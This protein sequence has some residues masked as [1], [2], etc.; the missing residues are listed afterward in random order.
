M[1]S[2]ARRSLRTTA[3]AAGIAALSVGIA[4]H[5]FAAP[6]APALPGADGLGAAPAPAVPNAD[7]SALEAMLGTAQSGNVSELPQ[8]FTFEGPTVNTAGPMPEFAELGLPFAP[9]APEADLLQAP[10][11]PAAGPEAPELAAPE[12][13]AAPAAPAAP[14][15]D[16][17]GGM[18][19]EDNQVTGPNMD[20]T[21]ADKTNNVGALS[22]MDTAKMMA[23]MAQKAMSG[24]SASKGN[25]I[26]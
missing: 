3:A 4:G 17:L 21:S 19:G 5:A 7:A 14:N 6:E 12:L 23:G 26:G 16:A 15:T 10:Q 13:P 25:S 24:E 20:P 2:L 1:S 9:A 22:Q 18:L 11:L 8:V